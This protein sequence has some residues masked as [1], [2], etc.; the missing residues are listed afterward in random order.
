MENCLWMQGR[1]SQLWQCVRDEADQ[2]EKTPP[3]P[4]HSIF[5]FVFLIFYYFFVIFCHVLC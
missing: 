5:I 2:I 1:L 3:P 4:T